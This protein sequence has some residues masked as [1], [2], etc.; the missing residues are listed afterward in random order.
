LAENWYLPKTG[1]FYSQDV[2][3]FRDYENFLTELTSP[4]TFKQAEGKILVGKPWS[5]T[6]QSI[7]QSWDVII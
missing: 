7:Y 1:I 3:I 5:Y 2:V 4:D 6:G